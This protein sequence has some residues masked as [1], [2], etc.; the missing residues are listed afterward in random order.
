M[1]RE[2][3]EISGLTQTHLDRAVTVTE[4][5]LRAAAR[6]AADASLPVNGEIV[7]AI[8]QVI[9]TNMQYQATKSLR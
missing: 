4:L 2:N 5:Q 3:N 6:L 7:A 8:A 1:D 9:A